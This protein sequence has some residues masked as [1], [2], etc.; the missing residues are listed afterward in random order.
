MVK[1]KQKVKE[2]ISISPWTMKHTVTVCDKIFEIESWGDLGTEFWMIVLNINLYFDI[3]YKWLKE[4]CI[5]LGNDEIMRHI[6]KVALQ[7]E[8]ERIKR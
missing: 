3:T 7:R 4:G 6:E 1:C 5:I 2:E 8:Y